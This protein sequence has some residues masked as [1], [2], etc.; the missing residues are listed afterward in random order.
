VA[1]LFTDALNYADELILDRELLPDLAFLFVRSDC[2]EDLLN[3][4]NG[5]NSKPISKKMTDRVLATAWEWEALEL[6][7][8]NSTVGSYACLDAAFKSMRDLLFGVSY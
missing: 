1:L 6:N 8:K 7:D 3:L 5:I 4:V 2:P